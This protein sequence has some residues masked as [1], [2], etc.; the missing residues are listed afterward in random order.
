MLGKTE[1]WRRGRQRMRW[2]DGI[3]DSMDMSLSKLQEIV[4]GR[5]AW[6]AAVHGVTNSQTQLSD[7]TTTTIR[8]G[9]LLGK[10]QFPKD[11][12]IPAPITMPPRA[13]SGLTSRWQWPLTQPGATTSQ[14]PGLPLLI[15]PGGPSFLP[16]YLDYLFMK[17][18]SHSSKCFQ[19]SSQK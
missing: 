2:L 3:T 11:L 16:L 9:T 1:G 5:E 18:Q 10:F 15:L 17:E 19:L 12:S 7:W 8:K 13:P 14:R 6:H 4:E